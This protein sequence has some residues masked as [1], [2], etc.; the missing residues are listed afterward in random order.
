MNKIAFLGAG[1]M[2]SAIAEGMLAKNL[3]T[4]GDLCC[5][6]PSGQSAAKLAV[7]TGITQA[8]SLVELL[9]GADI[10]IIAFKPQHLSLIDPTLNQL[11]QGKLV[12]SV[13]SGKS[14]AN[15]KRVLPLARNWVRA[16][17]NTPGRIGAGIT[18][19]CSHDPLAPSDLDKVNNLLGAL[20]RTIQLEEDQMDAVTAVSASGSGF[21]FE[22]ASAMLESAINVGLKP[23]T[24]KILVVETLLGSARLMARTDEDPN[25]LRDQVTSPNGTTLAGL[26]KMKAGNFRGLMRDAVSAAKIRAGELSQET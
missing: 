12:I 1:N 25:I 6:S 18:A 16:M 17:P 5:F 20:G 8:R 24:A 9:A 23:A 2:A 19:W 22:F 3:V 11:A 26:N 21:V 13:L 7:R 14:L 10:L 15:I 4:P